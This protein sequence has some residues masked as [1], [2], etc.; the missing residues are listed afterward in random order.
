M[1]WQMEHLTV[2]QAADL[3]KVPDQTMRK[4]IESEK[5]PVSAG[6]KVGRVYQ[7]FKQNFYKLYQIPANVKPLER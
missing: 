5:F 1:E 7:I 6:Q 2:H 4:I 3:I